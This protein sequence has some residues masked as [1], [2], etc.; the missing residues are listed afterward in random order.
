MFYLAEIC[1]CLFVNVWHMWWI[2]SDTCH[3]F[4][5]HNFSTNQWDSGAW[6]ISLRSSS[7][8]EVTFCS[9]CVDR[10]L[11]TVSWIIS[12]YNHTSLH[13]FSTVKKCR[14]FHSLILN[15]FVKTLTVNII[16]L[17]YQNAMNI[18]KLK[19]KIKNACV[20]LLNYFAKSH[21]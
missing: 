10:V 19:D 17:I 16:W 11:V 13:S 6:K 20:M 9:C 5:N 2:E 14:M 7:G 18:L 12:R 15:Q 4:E 8:A 21:L 1:I 3:I